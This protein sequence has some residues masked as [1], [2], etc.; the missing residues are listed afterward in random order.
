MKRIWAY[1]IAIIEL[2]LLT[3]SLEKSRFK[4][5]KNLFPFNWLSNELDVPM[6]KNAYSVDIITESGPITLK[7]QTVY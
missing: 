4:S 2:T 5:S 6:R 7:L 3:L 1:A